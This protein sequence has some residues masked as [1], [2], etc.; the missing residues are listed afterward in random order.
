MHKE[1]LPRDKVTIF[2]RAIDSA[3][4]IIFRDISPNT[5]I[6]QLKEEIGSFLQPI[7]PLVQQQSRKEIDTPK[8]VQSHE[9]PQLSLTA[10]KAV[11]PYEPNQDVRA[12]MSKTDP[13]YQTTQAQTHPIAQQMKVQSSNQAEPVKSLQPPRQNQTVRPNQRA[14]SKTLPDSTDSVQIVKP[15]DKPTLSYSMVAQTQKSNTND[16][17]A[18]GPSIRSSQP[19][20]KQTNVQ[21]LTRS[22]QPGNNQSAISPS[23]EEKTLT[24][25]ERPNIQPPQ[26][27][28][29]LQNPNR[30]SLPPNFPITQ[31]I[32][33]QLQP[34]RATSQPSLPNPPTQTTATAKPPKPR[35][36]FL[37]LQDH[38]I[39]EETLQSIP[40]FHN[41][42]YFMFST[43]RLETVQQQ[44][45]IVIP[46]NP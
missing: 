14:Q 16:Q 46:T 37:Y 32:S 45:D 1:T 9:Q 31:P 4:T 15:M 21:I 25:S 11:Q 44:E 40:N 3:Q 2:V 5:T 36:L 29:I 26:Q 22:S 13:I 33:Q 41:F 19:A 23:S 12:I 42:S 43:K 6:K 27:K 34:I 7:K 28:S 17:K 8:A 39:G 20:L 35:K 24:T 10:D 18:N 30:S 38:L